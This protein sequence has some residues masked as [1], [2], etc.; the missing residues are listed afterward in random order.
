MI[1]DADVEHEV[2]SALVEQCGASSKA[3]AAELVTAASGA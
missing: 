1:A 2:W 3:A